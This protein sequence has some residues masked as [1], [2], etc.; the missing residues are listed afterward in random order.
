MLILPFKIRNYKHLTTNVLEYVLVLL[1]VLLELALV[2]LLLLLLL[3]A[4]V[5]VFVL[6]QLVFV[7]SRRR[8]ENIPSLGQRV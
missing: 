7:Q 8:G 2:L 4:L 3:F 1:L 5:L 6:V